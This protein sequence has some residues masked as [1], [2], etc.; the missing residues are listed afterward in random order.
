MCFLFAF[1]APLFLP[2]GAS[3]VCAKRLPTRAALQPHDPARAAPPVT[4]H[5]PLVDALRQESARIR[6]CF[7]APGHARS[8]LIPHALADLAPAYALD[9]PELPAIGSLAD[10]RDANASPIGAAQAE[11]AK[12]AA[13][14]MR[15]DARFL[16][17]GATAGILA[18][19][20]ATM[21]PGDTVALPR[22]SHASAIHAL[23]LA[24]AKPVWLPP[25]MHDG[26]A[27]SVSVNSVKAALANTKVKALLALSPTYHGAVPDMA[28][29]CATAHASGAVVIVD[30]AHGA[31]FGLCERLPNSATFAGADI[32]VQSVHKT[33]PAL[34][35][36]AVLLFRKD[37]RVALAIDSAL[38]IVHSTSP[39][40][41]L[42][43]S[44]D[45][46]RA[47]LLTHGRLLADRA[48][49]RARMAVRRIEKVAGLSVLC[50]RNLVHAGAAFALDPLR[51]TV[52]LPNGVCGL[53][54]DDQLIEQFGV[55]VELPLPNSLTLVFT[56]AT[57]D[58]D[59]DALI[60][61]LSILVPA[62]ALSS[63]K[64][65]LALP[66]AVYAEHTSVTPRDAFFACS[67]VVSVSNAPGRLSADTL[68]PYPPG[69]PLIVPGERFTHKVIDYLVH[70][71]ANG[72]N[73]SG[74]LDD[75]LSSVRVIC[76]EDEKKL[77]MAT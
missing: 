44:I 52:L 3:P 29:L 55:Y 22:N 75:Q 18:A 8:A 62:A 40:A 48:V 61:A 47:H 54:L 39:S 68:C 70:V 53:S 73:V 50:E 51:V 28:A 69:I 77:L 60:H 34:S 27:H 14:C 24:G 35:Q 36:A 58:T 49:R 43:A 13:P 65:T 25:V 16:V 2:T 45:A 67:E 74:A 11:Y 57:A 42:L 59:V 31:H 9:L 20:L 66:T 26:L 72:G 30:E 71:A 76:K 5:A 21:K 63:D 4:P 17:G 46:V 37:S 41:L 23:V 56:L 6:A 10:A 7:F 32:V 15:Y 19:V 38:R 1:A 33:L 12:H 64:E